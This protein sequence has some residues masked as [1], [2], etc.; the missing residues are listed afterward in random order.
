MSVGIP[1]T[2]G[3]IYYITFTCLKWM[4]LFEMTKGYDL[5]YKWFDVLKKKE[6]II[7]GYVIMPNHLH[8]IIALRNASTTMN[9]IVSNGKRFLAYELVN[10]LKNAKCDAALDEMY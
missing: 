8:A 9:K 2:E 4:P 3:G 6:H 1:V 5:V 7:S 10:R